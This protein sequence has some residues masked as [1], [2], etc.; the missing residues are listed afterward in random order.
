MKFNFNLG[1]LAFSL[2]A[3]RSYAPS[4]RRSRERIPDSVIRVMV[5]PSLPPAK[6]FHM[7]IC[8]NI[9]RRAL[10]PVIAYPALV[11]VQARAPLH[12]C[13]LTYPGIIIVLPNAAVFCIVAGVEGFRVPLAEHDQCGIW[14]RIDR[15]IRSEAVEH[16]LDCI[17]GALVRENGIEDV[18]LN[19]Q[20]RITGHAEFSVCGRGLSRVGDSTVVRREVVGQ[21][22]GTDRR[23]R[24]AEGHWAA[25]QI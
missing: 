22:A 21:K 2:S 18:T 14:Q 16:A 6:L 5:P 13:R 9:V 24:R 17:A 23:V 15:S 1:S 10:M 19:V 25:L 11:A 3:E 4:V 20:A 8:V 12:Q 7:S